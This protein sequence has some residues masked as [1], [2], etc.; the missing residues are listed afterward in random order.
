MKKTLRLFFVGI[1]FCLSLNVWSVPL[2]VEDVVNSKYLNELQEKKV[3]SS[4]SN[5]TED[6]YVL[7]P[8]CEYTNLCNNRKITKTKGSFPFVL[9]YLF[10]LDKNEILTKNKSS[11]KGININDI[12]VL[13]RSASKMQG[14][15]YYSNTSKKYKVLYE[16]AYTIDN[17]KDR[18]RIPDRTEGSTKDEIYYLILD[19]AS[20]GVTGYS[21]L[22]NESENAIYAYLT[23]EDSLGLAFMKAINPKN[24]GV[25]IIA[26]DCGE[27]VVLYMNMDANCK[28]YPNIENIM[29]DSLRARIEALKE[30]I[31]KM[32]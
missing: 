8:N 15:K 23:N 4:L 19:D 20:F 12:S 28:K 30:W 9:E 18:N 21:E 6:D 24:L 25:S 26:V 3:V 2:K 32:F 16:H 17:P 7:L 22:I 31:V 13:M 29:T 10:L 27:K 1:F 5:N 14:M 11:R